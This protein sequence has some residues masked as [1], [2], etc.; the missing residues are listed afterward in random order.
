MSLA[1]DALGA[2]VPT[3]SIKESTTMT[4][5]TTTAWMAAV[6]LAFI[7]LPA[8]AQPGPGRGEPEYDLATETELEGT[9][10][11]DAACRVSS[12]TIA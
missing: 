7:T 3:E 4:D 5:R 9:G 1:A 10:I 8:L 11:A 12:K 6:L 2:P